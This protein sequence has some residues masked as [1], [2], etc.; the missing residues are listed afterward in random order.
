MAENE[1]YDVI[2]IGSGLGALSTAAVLSRYAGKKCLVLERHFKIGGFTHIFKRENKF[3]WDVGLHYVGEMLAG[4]ML[5]SLFDYISEGQIKWQKMPE[6]YEMFVYPDLSFPVR[7]GLQNY[8]SDLISRFP[9]EEQALRQ[10][11]KDLYKARKWIVRYVMSKVLPGFLKPAVRFSLKFGQNP[12]MLS[13]AEYMNARFQD[14]KLRALLVSQWGDYG[15]PPSQS[16]FGMHSTI[17]LHY[18]RGAYYPVGSSK[19]IADSIVPVIEKS[20]GSCRVNHEVTEI[21][22][23]NGRA[24]GV[25]AELIKGENRVP[26]KYYAEAVVSNTGAISTYLNLLPPQIPIPFREEIR[27]FQKGAANLTLYLGL[28]SD[29][30][31]LGFNGE[32]HWVYDA[33]DHDQIFAKMNEII[34]GK[35]HMAYLSFPSMKDPAAKSHT[36]EIITIVDKQPFE[37][38]A[39][40]P[41]KNR[42]KEYVQLKEKMCDALVSFVE[43]RYPGFS[44]LIEYRELSTPLSTEY[45]TGHS[46]GTIYGIPAIRQRYFS[47]WIDFKTPVKNLYMAGADTPVGHGIGGVLMSGLFTAAAVLK[48]PTGPVK[49]MKEIGG[50]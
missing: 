14:P 4:S 48:L 43:E 2:L 1:K 39:D 26:V 9:A 10:Y 6:T 16:T 36:M 28:K 23:E 41:W 8:L 32:N 21:I 17:V 15:L 46:Q 31:T 44:K 42:A 29:P 50:K 49:L 35:V 38:W 18:L 20:G 45:F 37:P 5:K 30:R 25:K 40:Q 3:L 27:N 34:E 11:F 19:V 22:V 47:K 33:Y 24:V 7:S 12:A 13:T